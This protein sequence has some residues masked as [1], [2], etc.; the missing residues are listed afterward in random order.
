MNEAPRLSPEPAAKPGKLTVNSD[1]PL[2]AFEVR[3][4]SMR[5]IAEGITPK[6]LEVPPGLYMATGIRAGAPNLSELVKIA[7]G[8]SETVRL[9][10]KD[11]TTWERT[12]NA[13]VDL[14]PA[15]F[16]GAPAPELFKDTA[17]DV[18]PTVPFRVRF[19]KLES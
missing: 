14:A 7:A 9:T 15:V 1:P 2:M 12:V 13:V 16:R 10:A 4:A 3:D 19:F 8:A 6:Q 11:P 5:V 18:K 17:P